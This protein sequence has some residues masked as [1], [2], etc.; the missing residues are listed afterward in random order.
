[1]TSESL[2]ISVSVS[3]FAPPEFRVT[4]SITNMEDFA[5]DFECPPESDMNPTD[6]CKLW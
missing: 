5:K 3:R 4:G 2:D 6:K 1:M